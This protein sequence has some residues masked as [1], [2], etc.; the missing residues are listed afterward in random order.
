MRMEVHTIV[1][2]AAQAILKAK[3]MSLPVGS[4]DYDYV[5]TPKENWRRRVRQ[6]LS[7]ERFGGGYECVV[8]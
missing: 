1:V 8:G 4:T 7:I 3:N 5:V 2:Q 6:L